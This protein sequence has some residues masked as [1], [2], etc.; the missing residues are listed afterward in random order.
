MYE[1][2]CTRTLTKV[3]GGKNALATNELKLNI[4]EKEDDDE[5]EGEEAILLKS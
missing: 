5:E 1:V 4:E 3:P 2:T